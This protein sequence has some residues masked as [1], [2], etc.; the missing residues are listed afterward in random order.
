MELV[1]LLEGLG[2]VAF[3]ESMVL[4]LLVMGSRVK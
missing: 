4:G 1:I 2:L 3:W